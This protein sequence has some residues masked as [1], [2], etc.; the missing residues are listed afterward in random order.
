MTREE[1]ARAYD[2]ALNWMRELYPGLHGATKEDAEHYFPELKESEDERIRK[3][4]ED[5]I[6]V[7]SKTQGEWLNG[8]DMD[9]L[10][11]HLR[12]AFGALE[13]QKEQKEQKQKCTAYLDLSS[14]NEFEACML[15]YLQSAANRKDDAMIIIDTK[16]YAAQ[17]MEIARKEQKS[18]KCIDFDNEFEN[19]VSHLIASVLNGEHEYNEGFVK[20]VA[21]SLLGYA[22][23]EQKPVEQGVKGRRGRI[24]ITPE[25]IR[26]KAENFLSKMEPPYDADDIC[27]AYETGAMEN[28]KP[29]EWS[30]EDEKM[31]NCCISSIEEAKEY[32]WYAYKKT[33][34]DTSYDREIDW[35]KSLRP[36]W[37]PSEVC[38][39]QKGDPDPAGVWKP[40]KEQM[41]SLRDTIVNTKGYQ[42]SAYLPELYEQLKKLM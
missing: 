7:Y 39:G 19:Q 32:R 33:D 14:S 22:K 23:K 18:I 8:Y 20:Y 2:E 6:R 42:Y 10:V 29:A 13:K 30:E 15:R 5:V 24:G 34:G 31:L 27:S 16:C 28:A 35:L 25:H 11:V 37:K 41:D 1:K 9:T 12:E 4:I 17:L 26:K 36:S 40:G 38:Y 3:I 21:Q